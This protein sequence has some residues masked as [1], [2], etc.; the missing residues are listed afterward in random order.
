MAWLGDDVVVVVQEAAPKGVTVST[1]KLTKSGWVSGPSLAENAAE[2]ARFTPPIAPA[3]AQDQLMVAYLSGPS[4]FFVSTWSAKDG[5]SV[6]SP[7]IVAPLSPSHLPSVGP[8]TEHLL[9][10][11]LVLALI[12]AYYLW[13]QG[14]IAVFVP[15][16][17]EHQYA[18][19]TNRAL[20]LLLDL[21]I[22]A[23]VWA[24]LL[25]WI[26]TRGEDVPTI[27]EQLLLR[28]EA[29]PLVWF[30]GYAI[31][32]AVFAVYATIFEYFL[33]ATPGK[34]IVGCRV[35]IEQ[36]RRGGLKAILIRNL[37]RPIEFHLPAIMLMV[38]LTPSRQRLGDV[39][40]STVVVE[41]RQ[42]FDDSHADV[43][44]GTI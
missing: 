8:S 25:Y 33:G 22:I 17:E 30:W 10:Y 7:S 6:E 32:G 20:A 31:I 11:A 14:K 16:A 2:V 37:V 41:P 35:V 40:A 36:S 9:Q 27:G 3:L 21:I 23:P 12:T 18:R 5:S 34:R 19:L 43:D 38:F 28:P 44:D 4:D 39:L 42:D 13:R 15:I 24:S 29:H 1:S 26:G